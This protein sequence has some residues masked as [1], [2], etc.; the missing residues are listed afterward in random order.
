M[1]LEDEGLAVERDLK[2]VHGI[3]Q[4]LTTNATAIGHISMKM[5]TFHKYRAIHFGRSI[6]FKIIAHTGTASTVMF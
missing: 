6:L 1:Y 5:G 4:L 3:T 2:G